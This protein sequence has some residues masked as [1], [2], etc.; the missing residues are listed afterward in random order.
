[1]HVCF[2]IARVVED[3]SFLSTAYL[4]DID[5]PR[6]EEILADRAS[7]AWSFLNASLVDRNTCH[8]STGNVGENSRA[9]SDTCA[10]DDRK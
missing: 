5:N 8:L 2:F 9:N 10:N 7:I 3:E 6:K 4:S 1:M